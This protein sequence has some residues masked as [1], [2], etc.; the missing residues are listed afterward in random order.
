MFHN[1]DLKI[2]YQKN[3]EIRYIAYHA[4]ISIALSCIRLAAEFYTLCRS[5]MAL[6][7]F[8]LQVV[9]CFSTIL[10]VIT[11]LYKYEIVS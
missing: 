3:G 10:A 7:N 6:D 2:T 4:C 11:E 5:F 9:L 8:T 1:S